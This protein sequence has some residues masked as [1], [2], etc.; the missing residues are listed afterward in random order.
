[1]PL[2]LFLGHRL[3]GRFGDLSSVVRWTQDGGL[4]LATLAVT[5]LALWLVWGPEE[6]K[7]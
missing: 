6:S 4:W 1:V 2:L 3:G 5:L 7:L